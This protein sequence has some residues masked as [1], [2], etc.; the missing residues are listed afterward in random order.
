MQKVFVAYYTTT[1]EHPNIFSQKQHVLVTN[2]LI[3]N[4]FLIKILFRFFNTFLYVL[5]SVIRMRI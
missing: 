2:N 4:F 5:K 3:M 1:L